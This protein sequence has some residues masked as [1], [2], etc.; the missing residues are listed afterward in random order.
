MKF[1]MS[2]NIMIQCLALVAQLLNGLSDVVPPDK[3]TYLA[4]AIMVV[5]GIVA[6]LAH[7]SNTDG[8][9]QTT[10]FVPRGKEGGNPPGTTVTETHQVTT[11]TKD[12]SSQNGK[13]E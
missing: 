7:H 13:G 4:I 10:A 12:E 5:Q 2:V 11:E 9:P 3:K 6:I 1:K 8:T